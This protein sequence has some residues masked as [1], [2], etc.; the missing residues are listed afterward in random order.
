MPGV[1]SVDYV[2]PRTAMQRLKEAYERAAA[3]LDLGGAT[4]TALREPRDRLTDPT[5]PPASPLAPD[6]ARSS[7]SSRS[8]R[9][10][11]LL[12]IIRHVARWGSWRSGWWG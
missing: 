11:Q 5:S 4:I 6:H 9:L 12:G 8:R 2:Q 10:R 3:E 1:A 7:G